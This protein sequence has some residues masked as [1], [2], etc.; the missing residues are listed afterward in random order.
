MA[1]FQDW[2]KFGWLKTHKTSREEIA[3]L[4]A[5]ADRDIAACQTPGLVADW[6]LNIAYNA[7]LQLAVAALAA[8]GYRAERSNHHYHVI[9]SLELT[10]GASASTIGKFDVLRKKR[11][12]TDYE[13]AET[14]SDLEAEEMRKLA[15]SLRKRTEE[16]I[17]TNYPDYAP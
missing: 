2:L 14:V 15:V 3:D 13:R 8:A 1:N 4:L 16:W 7:A 5:V 9:Q 6:R 11:N 12:I 10:I 17:W